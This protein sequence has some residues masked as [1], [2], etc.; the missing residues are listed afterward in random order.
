MMQSPNL[1]QDRPSATLLR[2]QDPAALPRVVARNLTSMLFEANLT[3]NA[4]ALKTDMA[5]SV[6]VRYNREEFVPT[7]ESLQK[8]AK[9]L[10]V[11]KEPTFLIQTVENLVVDPPGLDRRSQGPYSAASGLAASDVLRSPETG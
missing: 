9:A 6:V 4:L 5:Y 10:E 2:R 7:D 1:R 11:K 8:L 3:V